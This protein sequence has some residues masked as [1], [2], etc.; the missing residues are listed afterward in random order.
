[1]TKKILAL[2]IILTFFPQ[3]FSEKASGA[4]KKSHLHPIKLQLSWVHGF[5]FAGYYAA[6]EKGFYR[7]AGLD[8]TIQPGEPNTN[9]VKLVLS[10]AADV[11]VGTS[12]IMLYRL[13]GE[14]VIAL[15][16]IFQHSPSVYLS[17]KSSGIKTPQD[18]A[19]KRVMLTEKSQSAEFYTLLDSEG[20]PRDKIKR[21]PPTSDIN[22]LISGKTDV[23][24]AYLTNEPF[25][26]IK[27][28]IPF[29]SIRP[30]VYGIDF[31][32][33]CLFTSEN[34]TAKHPKAINAFLDASIKGWEY[35]MA[36]PDEIINLILTKYKTEFSKDRLQFQAK[37][38]RELMMP[39]IVKIGHMNPGRWTHI[40]R[41]F[42]KYEKTAPV[43]DLDSLIEKFMY[44]PQDKYDYTWIYWCFAG[45]AL[46][47]SGMLLY[48]QSLK[49][50][51]SKRT[52]ELERET[53]EHKKTAKEKELL[54]EELKNFI[55]TQDQVIENRTKALKESELMY[56]ATIDNLTDPIYVINTEYKI[57]LCNEAL[58]DLCRKCGLN[59]K[60]LVGKKMIEAFTFLNKKI[61][62]DHSFVFKNGKTHLAE[63]CTMVNGEKV[64]TDTCHVPIKDENGK[65]E[66]VVTVIRDVS[67]RVRSEALIKTSEANLNAIFENANSLIAS[68]G[69]DMRYLKLN[70]AF[71]AT[72]NSLFGYKPEV[73][74]HVFQKTLK[75]R[76]SFWEEIYKRVL[77]GERFREEFSFMKGEE[78][79]YYEGWFT[80]IMEDGKITGFSEIINDITDR[81]KVEKEA[82]LRRE[83]L[84]Q[85]DKMA[86][87]G[88]LVAGVAHEI[89]N[90][91]NSIV[92]NAPLLHRSWDSAVPI[93]DTYKDAYGDFSVGGLPYSEMRELVPSLIEGIKGGADRIKNIVSGLKDYARQESGAPKGD[94]CINDAAEQS[95]MILSNMIKKSTNNLVVNRGEGLPPVHASAQKIEQIIINLLQN[96]CAALRSS[97]DKIEITTLFNKKD[98]NVQIIIEDEG[99][100]ISSNDLNYIT[101]PFFTTKRDSGGTGLGLSISSGIVKDYGGELKIES[102][103]NVGTKV[104][105]Y[106]PAYHK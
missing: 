74:M 9:T 1:M 106:F 71:A 55:S 62:E 96:S 34:E 63:D 11:G 46:F 33:D 37:K 19:G 58:K 73:G 32:G 50:L 80:P 7:D 29:N 35:A 47:A 85:A 28:N 72:V 67:E 99:V 36:H 45:L 100:G 44:S 59:D 25:A 27:K 103:E 10:G 105:V 18:L 60:R 14:P 68:I 90:P 79:R 78:R 66:S 20:V 16:A 23:F 48:S 84:I 13:K 30:S 31:Y 82:E 42:I 26:L 70:R 86:S 94:V 21:I 22:D 101:D 87:L 93:L 38:M 102:T 56:H 54:N 75:H 49:R 89:N 81:K 15:A 5:Q 43:S 4:R 40:G 12:D 6:R 2:L 76:K 104:T 17:L 97:K 24:D 65:V 41:T 91:N 61:I 57:V 95:L 92:M 8:V 3:A 64:F 98:D 51:V 52:S 83:Q 53:S 77:K 69:N 88:I 39:D